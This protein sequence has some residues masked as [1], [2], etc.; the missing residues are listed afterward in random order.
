MINL[1]TPYRLN[2]EGKELNKYWFS[3]GTKTVALENS[4]AIYEVPSGTTRTV[5]IYQQLINF[6]KLSIKGDLKISG[7]LILR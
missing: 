4:S 1:S 7:Q 5:E 2:T 6:N 3:N